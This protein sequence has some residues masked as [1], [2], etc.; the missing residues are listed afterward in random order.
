[1]ENK[2]KKHKQTNTTLNV[3]L[4]IINEKYFCIPTICNILFLIG[5]LNWFKHINDK[6][7]VL[8]HFSE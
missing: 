5:S 8:L 7:Q 2:Q 3:L 6:L 4:K 1:M